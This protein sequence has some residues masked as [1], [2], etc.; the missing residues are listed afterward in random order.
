MALGAASASWLSGAEKSSPPKQPDQSIARLITELG[1]QD[2]RTREAASR[3][4]TAKGPVAV[5]ALAK[6][7]QTDDLE[8]SYRAVRILESLMTSGDGATQDRI[9][10]SLKALAGRETTSAAGLASDVLALYQFTLSDRAVEQ[11]RKLGAAVALSDELPFMEPGYMQ[12]T[13][14]DGW[15]GTSDD[16]KLLKQV[17]NLQWL[18]VINVSLD[19]SDLGT[20]REL[21]QVMQIDLYGAGVSAEAAD[22]LAAALPNAMVDRRNGALLGVS[23]LPNMPNCIISEVRPGTAAESAGIRVGDE[24]ITFDGHPVHNFEEFTGLVAAKKGGDQVKLEFRRE[25]QVIS[26]DVTLGRWTAD[27]G[28]NGR[29]Q[30]RPFNPQP[31]NPPVLPAIPAAP[32]K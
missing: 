29:F 14:T 7:A 20:L 1:S 17:R 3:Q 31:F 16:L 2:Y 4:L 18:R 11:L 22:K 30:P 13:L 21:S 26:K 5:D 24:I 8:V 6:A 12:I 32:N 28:G 23:G 9:A 15:K 27:V 19:D 10:E 25:E